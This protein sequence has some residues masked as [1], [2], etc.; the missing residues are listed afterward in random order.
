MQEPED[1]EESLPPEV[2]LLVNSYK[3]CFVEVSG[4]GR[5]HGFEHEIPTRCSVPI[6]S[7]P[8][9]LTWEE[10]DHLSKELREM[11][12]LGLIRPS[13]GRWTSPVFFV[14]KKDGSLRLVVDY[15]RLNE[16]TI[17]DAYPLPHIDDLLGSMGGATWF[18]TLDAASGYWQIPV[19]EDSIERTGF[20]TSQGT[21]E[22][23]TM[24]FGLTSAPSTFQRCMNSLLAPY[25]GLFV[26]V[27]IDDIIIF[28]RTYERHLEHLEFVFATCRA[29][30]LRLKYKKCK[31]ARSSVEYLGHVVSNQGLLPSPY[32]T[33]KL[34]MMAP[35]TSID[36]VRSFLGMANYYK[37]FVPEFAEVAAPIIRLLRKENPF[38]WTQEHDAAFNHIKTVLMSPPLLAFPDREQVQ[39]LTT[40]A[41]GVALGAVL[42]QS[43]QG[44]SDGE[45]VI[46]YESRILRGPELRYSAVHQ[47][48]LAV[49][50]AV[51]KFRH[52]L[53]GRRFILRT[54]NAALTYV[55]S[56]VNRP[57]PKLQRWSAALMEYDFEVEHHPG[58]LNP[59][60]ALSRLVHVPDSL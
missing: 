6:R 36:G 55:F 45:T 7:R 22:F 5:V 48:A 20:V 25:L 32:N 35:P 58:R 11:L 44:T 1:L 43:P 4:L 21:F 31:F 49:V 16:I 39:V 28:S 3:D 15:R 38:V 50:W 60:D 42:S 52:Y 9:R 17:K 24:P 59:A 2:E 56:N 8:Y 29:A 33:Q 18:S 19:A 13:R 57:S 47:E 23:T 27:F 14:R 41:S 46:A 30:N 40:D 37:R 10:Q 34:Q 26:Y 53:A 54:D 51:Q 12:D